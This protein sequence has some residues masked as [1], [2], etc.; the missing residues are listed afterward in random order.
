MD[1]IRSCGPGG[2]P[3]M[4]QCPACGQPPHFQLYCGMGPARNIFYIWDDT[5]PEPARAAMI[6]K[7]M[8]ALG[9]EDEYK[10]RYVGDQPES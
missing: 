10:K 2:L 1:P 8:R 7:L 4:I 5:P 3:E 6:L 9:V